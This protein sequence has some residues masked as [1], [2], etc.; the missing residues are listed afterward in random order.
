MRLP[1]S[2]KDQNGMWIM[3]KRSLRLLDASVCFLFERPKWYVDYVKKKLEVAR[4]IRVLPGMGRA[5]QG[6]N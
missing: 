4:R 1:L 6:R 5:G 3:S 2:L